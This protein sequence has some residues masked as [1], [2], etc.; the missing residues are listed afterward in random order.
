MSFYRHQVPCLVHIAMRQKRL[1]PF[2][3]RVIG[4]AEGRVL[5]IGI[6]SGL[7]LPLYGSPA[8]SVV[9]LEPSSEL[10]RMARGR[11][12]RT[13]VPVELLSRPARAAHRGWCTASRSSPRH[14]RCRHREASAKAIPLG[15]REIPLH[16]RL[17]SEGSSA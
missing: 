1:V 13:S 6:G 11:G 10:L 17:K 8:H 14:P 16:Q 12:A 9:A 7:N 2:R 4:A 5:E 15:S 3:R